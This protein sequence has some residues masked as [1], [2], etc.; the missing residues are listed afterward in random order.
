MIVSATR[1]T[2]IRAEPLVQRRAVSNRRGYFKGAG[3]DWPRGIPCQLLL[4]VDA[5]DRHPL[6]S[7]WCAPS[8]HSTFACVPSG[9]RNFR[10]PRSHCRARLEPPC[11]FKGSGEFGAVGPNATLARMN[12]FS[13]AVDKPF[14]AHPEEKNEPS[15]N[16]RLESRVDR[17]TPWMTPGRRIPSPSYSALRLALRH[18]CAGS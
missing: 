18:V 10:E 4:K 12:A 15:Y 16:Y 1:I 2:T 7:L 8:V 9:T 3:C 11:S 14:G 13:S 6:P 5:S 17:Q